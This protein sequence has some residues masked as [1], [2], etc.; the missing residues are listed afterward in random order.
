M[1]M[2]SF[3]KL[4]AIPNSSPYDEMA[5]VTSSAADN[6]SIWSDNPNLY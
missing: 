6:S 1:T 3:W 5:Q 4:V 2:P